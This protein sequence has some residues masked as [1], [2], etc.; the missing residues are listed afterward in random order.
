M[1]KNDIVLE[2]KSVVDQNNYEKK[3]KI[4]RTNQEYDPSEKLGDGQGDFD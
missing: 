3:I 1:K 4:Y 2:R